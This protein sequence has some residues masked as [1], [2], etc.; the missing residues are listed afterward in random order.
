MKINR[1]AVVRRLGSAI[2]AEISGVDLAAGV[3]DE[4]IGFIQSVFL[5]YEVICIR[6]QAAM[7]PE[8]QLAFAARWGKISIHPYIP[9]IEG[10]PGIMRIYDPNPITQTWHADTTH[11]AAP[12]ALTLLLARVLP[13]IGGDT[14]FASAS[15]AYESLSPSLKAT[16]QT[17][18]AVHR[19]TERAAAAGLDSA[20]VTS[21]H[22]VVRTHP[23]SGRKA[24]FVNGNY[25]TEFEGWTPEESAPLLNYLYGVIARPEFTYRHR[26]QDGDLVIWDNRSTQHAVVG[27]TKGAERTLHRVTIA[28]DVP[29]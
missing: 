14:M 6:G 20:A 11:S 17:L 4:T 24:I 19:G 7:T 27:D 16:L 5:E 22:P 18:R 8:H 26:W 12:P 10:H 9:S 1:Q 28:G 23:V 25:V 21:V 13:P 15:A 29:Y 3:D 2:G